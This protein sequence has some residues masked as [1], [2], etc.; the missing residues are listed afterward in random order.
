MLTI[1]L[2]LWIT[3]GLMDDMEDNK[4]LPVPEKYLTINGQV[5]GMFLLSS[6]II[7][8]KMMLIALVIIVTTYIVLTIRIRK[9]KT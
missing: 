5:I 9:F 2:A 1:W 4:E 8:M 7:S 6:L 3:R